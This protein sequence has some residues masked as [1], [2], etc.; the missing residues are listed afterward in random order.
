ME[1]LKDQRRFCDETPENV[2][3][4][5]KFVPGRLLPLS[6]IHPLPSSL[7]YLNHLVPEQAVKSAV[8]S[9]PLQLQH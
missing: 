8:L 7:P 2:Q 9:F 4:T 5:C 6:N 1:Y 3:Q